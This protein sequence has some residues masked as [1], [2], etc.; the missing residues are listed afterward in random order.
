VQLGIRQP[1]H[2]VTVAIVRHR[3]TRTYL[4]NAKQLQLPLLI[5]LK[6]CT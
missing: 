1:W 4:H 3:N 5:F 2:T 6:Q